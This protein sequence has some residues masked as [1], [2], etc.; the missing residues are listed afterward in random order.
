LGKTTSSKAVKTDT[1]KVYEISDAVSNTNYKGMK[2][3]GKMRDLLNKLA[4][5]I[6]NNPDAWDAY[7]KKHNA[8]HKQVY[9]AVT[10]VYEDNRTDYTN[11]IKDSNHGNQGLVNYDITELQAYINKAKY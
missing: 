11:V 4:G 8:D 1:A 7:G 6:K 3:V 10:G 9:I 2:N 5:I